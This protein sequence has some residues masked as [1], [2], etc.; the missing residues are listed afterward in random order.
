MNIITV[1]MRSLTLKAVQNFS[2]WYQ[3]LHDEGR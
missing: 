1:S 3:N 2:K